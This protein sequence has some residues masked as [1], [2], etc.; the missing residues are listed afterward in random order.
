[1]YNSRNIKKH[2]GQLIELDYSHKRN[3]LTYNK[4]QVGIITAT[5]KKHI[6]FCINNEEIETA[7]NYDQINEISKPKK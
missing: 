4:K 5:T 2:K 3:G 1:M 6:L 7:L